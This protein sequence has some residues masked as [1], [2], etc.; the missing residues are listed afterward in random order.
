MQEE[1]GSR[2]GKW[3]VTVYGF[4]AGHEVIMIGEQFLTRYNIMAINTIA[5][6]A[7]IRGGMSEHC[8]D[9][10]FIRGIGCNDSYLDDILNMD[11]MLCTRETQGMGSYLRL[12]ELPKH[13]LPDE[14]DRYMGIYDG[15]KGED[16]PEVPLEAVKGNQELAAAFSN[17]CRQ[18]RDAFCNFTPG[19]SESMIKNFMVKLFF[20]A[21]CGTGSLLGKWQGAVGGK[22]VLT[23]Q[24]KKQEYLFCYLLSLMGIDVLILSPEGELG[25]DS[26]LL[27][28]SRLMEL[29]EVRTANIPGFHPEIYREKKKS[30]IYEDAAAVKDTEA[31]EVSGIF[32]RPGASEETCAVQETAAPADT[33]I[34]RPGA[35][36]AHP[37]SPVR[38]VIPGRDRGRRQ[39][40]GREADTIAPS[41]G[42]QPVRVQIPLRPGTLP[43]AGIQSSAGQPAGAG[44]Q[45]SAGQSSAAAGIQSSAGWP[46]A[47]AGTQTATVRIPPR[48]GAQPSAGRVSGGQ[49]F[50]GARQELAFEQ[51][52]LLASSIVMISVKDKTGKGIG[53]GSG[54]MVGAKGYILTNFHVVNGGTNFSVQIEDDKK[55]YDTDE[56][57]KYNHL[58]DMALIRIDRQLTPL[59]VYKGSQPLVRGQ[60]VVA[61]GSPLGLFNSVSDGI[62]SGFRNLDDVDMI[63]FTAPISHGSS[64]GAVLNMFGEV[65]G[66]STAGYDSG[67]N[68]NLAVDYKCITPFIRGFI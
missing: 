47:G 53:S 36:A 1:A 56:L 49:P 38:V 18:V 65:I 29:G 26:R 42:A 60:K 40:P 20:W 8:K 33:G 61:I 30:E 7:G 28:L 43:G 35:S 54:I 27:N 10:Y 46:S 19:A 4:H 44:I 55:S 58:L 25:L 41:P 57:I 51:L 67:Q 52:A 68:L 13:C 23:S 9:V 21:E 37:A 32:L 6:F 63:Q 3:D 2:Y 15:W 45:S 39:P 14:T 22:F 31:S 62:I 5:S 34:V 16:L 11:Q 64:G 66:I 48:P 17:A 12:E 24:V 59:P 50:S